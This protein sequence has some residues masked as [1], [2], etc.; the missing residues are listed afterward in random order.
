MG[1]PKSFL[2]T[3]QSNPLAKIPLIPPGGPFPPQFT[4]MFLS[5]PMFSPKT[6]PAQP[7]TS[8]IQIWEPGFQELVPGSNIPKLRTEKSCRMQWSIF[9]T[10]PYVASYGRK[11]FRAGWGKIWRKCVCRQDICCV[12]RPC[13][14]NV[15]GDVLVD[16]C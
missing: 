14:G 3:I 2:G 5:N 1:L 16:V 6:S 8:K 13:V 10:E 4:G 11:P 15:G 9:Q 12:G 7:D